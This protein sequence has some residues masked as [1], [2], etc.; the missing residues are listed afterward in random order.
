MNV[1]IT[2]AGDGKRFRDAGFDCPKYEIHA[3]GR[4]LFEWSMTSLSRFWQAGARAVFMARRN[5]GVPA[6]IAAHAQH[7]GISN[8]EVV[9]IDSLT[10]G[11]A[12]TAMMAE[13]AIADAAAPVAIFNI[14]TYVDPDALRPE[15]VRGHGWIPCFPGAGEGWSFASVADDD[16]V[17]QLREKVRISDWAT[18]GLYH[19]ASFALF[20]Q[21]YQLHFAHTDGTE[22]GERYIAPMYNTLLALHP[23]VHIERLPL[24]AVI[25]LGTPAEL[26]A[27]KQ[28][29]PPA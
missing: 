21:V 24:D 16:R 9:E 13:G 15:S 25:P 19:F 2:M 22:K 28:Q 3:H 6:F 27:F 14:D 11:Q 20:R 12:T 4:T 7:C 23:D 17:L 18:V 5:Q 8:F 26:E 1:I 10:D 29:R